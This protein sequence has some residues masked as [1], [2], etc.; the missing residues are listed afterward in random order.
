MGI[1]TKKYLKKPP[2][3]SPIMEKKF[4]LNHAKKEQ[5]VR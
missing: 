5:E 4:K 3:V 2:L 1:K